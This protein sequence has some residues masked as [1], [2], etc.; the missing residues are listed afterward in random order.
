[1]QLIKADLISG[2]VVYIVLDK[3]VCL[4]QHVSS[5]GVIISTVTKDYVTTL[6]MDE[7]IKILRQM[8]GRTRK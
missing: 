8:Q 3:I 6:S 4:Q 2:D 7:T 5:G 1:M